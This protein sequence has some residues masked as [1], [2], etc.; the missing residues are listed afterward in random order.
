MAIIS[1]GLAKKNLKVPV[2]LVTDKWTIAWLKESNM[3]SK[4]ESIFDKII[5]VEKPVTKNY[6]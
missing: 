2:S 1:G 5:E 4:A 3:Y 6:R